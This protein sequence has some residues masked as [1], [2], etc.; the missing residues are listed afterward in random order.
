VIPQYEVSSLS[1]NRNKKARWMN[2]FDIVYD[3]EE[4]NTQYIVACLG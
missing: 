4:E 1:K 3:I 2:F